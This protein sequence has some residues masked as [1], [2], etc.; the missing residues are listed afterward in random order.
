MRKETSMKQKPATGTKRRHS[1]QISEPDNE[2]RRRQVAEAAYYKAQSRGFTA[3]NEE[4][5]WLEAEREFD[6]GRRDA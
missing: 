1:S 5:D 2:E 6:A 4:L 3:G